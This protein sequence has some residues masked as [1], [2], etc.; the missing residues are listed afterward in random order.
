MATMTDY[1]ADIVE[2]PIEGGWLYSSQYCA[3]VTSAADLLA[4]IAG[5]SHYIRRI[6]LCCGTSTATIMLGADKSG[7]ALVHTYIGPISFSVSSTGIE[8][9]F[10]GRALKLPAAHTFAIDGVAT[11]PVWIYFEYK[12]I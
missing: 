10:K 12:T 6:I 11:A 1:G 3:D 4:A 8:I 9:D 2:P 5:K 7:N